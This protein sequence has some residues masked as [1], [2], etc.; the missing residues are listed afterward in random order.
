MKKSN[1]ISIPALILVDIQKGLDDLDHYGQRNNPEAEENAAHLLEHWRRRSWPLFHVKHNALNEESKLRPGLPG[2]A[3]K[4]IV[5]PSHG[6]TIIEKNTNSAFVNTDLDSQLKRERID[7]LIFAGI[8]TDHCISASV[9][10]A[11]DLGYVVFVVADATAAFDRTGYDKK[12]FSAEE[13]HEHALAS[14]HGE[15][16]TVM[17]MEE[18]IK[19]INKK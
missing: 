3:I 8:A 16:A 18:V 2:N 7:Q 17:D 5:R 11:S 19:W 12:K 1:P 9:R 13:V 14:L 6:E 4:D 15:F 10:S